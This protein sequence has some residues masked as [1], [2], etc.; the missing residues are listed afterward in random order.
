MARMASAGADYVS[1]ISQLQKLSPDQL[2]AIASQ[3]GP[4]G[5]AA[6]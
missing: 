1:I 3:P 4:Q 2:N 5:Q 6:T